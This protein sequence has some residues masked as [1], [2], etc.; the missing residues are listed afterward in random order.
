MRDFPQVRIK[1]E[2]GLDLSGIPYTL[3]GFFQI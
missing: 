1:G 3:R 2:V